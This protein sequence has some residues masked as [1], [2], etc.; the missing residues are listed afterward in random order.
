MFSS[1]AGS[2]KSFNEEREVVGKDGEDSVILVPSQMA[3]ASPRFKSNCL[4]K[5]A[6]VRVLKYKTPRKPASRRKREVKEKGE[7]YPAAQHN[8][9]TA[10][11]RTNKLIFVIRF[12]YASMPYI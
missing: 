2:K 6:W 12:L 9:G 11:I 7:K 8:D 5:R 1:I 3:Q 4:N 10:P